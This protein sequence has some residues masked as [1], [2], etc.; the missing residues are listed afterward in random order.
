[1][2]NQ[3]SS[4]G[5]TSTAGTPVAPSSPGG[6]SIDLA[7]ETVGTLPAAKIGAHDLGGAEHNAATL[8]ELNTK[9]SDAT[10]VDTGDARFSDA[11][12][13]TAHDLGGA[14][15]TADTLANL[16]AKVSDGTLIDT[17]D[18]RLSDARTPTA[19]DLGGA[20]HS[21]DTLANLN[22][23]VSDAILI[24]AADPRVLR[25]ATVT[26]TSAQ[27]LALFT[28]PI[29]LIAAQGASTYIVIESIEVLNDFNTAA[30]VM[31][32]AGLTVRYT[33]GTGN[34]IAAL[35]QAFGQR[36]RLEA[37][38]VGLHGG[39]GLLRVQTLERV[40]EAPRAHLDVVGL[41]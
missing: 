17:G 9:I 7:S 23:K 39:L 20:E 34:Q 6:T 12:T 26:V 18:A 33:N 16:N 27:I 38:H 28:T 1:M 2:A 4:F 40:V 21:V 37:A 25:R 3:S 13:P 22:S 32:A 15:H 14:E 31:N 30:Y 29:T 24:D 35:T 10:V 36:A 8:A 11:R 41:A 19:H 5:G